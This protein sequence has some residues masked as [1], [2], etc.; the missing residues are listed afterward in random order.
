MIISVLF[1][2]YI[3]IHFYWIIKTIYLIQNFSL[4]MNSSD[5]NAENLVLILH[6]MIQKNTRII[7]MMMKYYICIQYLE[8]IMIWNAHEK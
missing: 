6:I 5:K 7:I 1:I 4:L 3:I 2:C 8:M